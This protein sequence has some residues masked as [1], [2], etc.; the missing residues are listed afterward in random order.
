MSRL[1]VVV[2]LAALVA[3]VLLAGTPPTPAGPDA[4]V[5]TPRVNSPILVTDAASGLT[6]ISNVGA[7]E[8]RV[9][10]LRGPSIVLVREVFLPAGTAVTG[11][12]PAGDGRGLIVEAGESRY[13]LDL[14][15]FQVAALPQPMHDLAALR[16]HASG[17]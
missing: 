14:R 11:L 5:A 13:A 16:R 1:A 10:Y 8:V 12:V 4:G 15:T 17:R 2:A 3:A 6:A 7:R 9:L